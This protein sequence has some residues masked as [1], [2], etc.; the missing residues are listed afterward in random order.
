MMVERSKIVEIL[1]RR[2]QDARADWVDRQL[3]EQVDVRDNASLFA[4][5]GI[6]P[7]E[8][9][10]PNPSDADPAA[11]RKSSVDG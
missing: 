1:R 8:L 6:D 7:N 3:P 9:T 2:G 4:T 5:L 10:D 11:T